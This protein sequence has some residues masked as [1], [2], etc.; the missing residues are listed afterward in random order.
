MTAFAEVKGRMGV[1]EPEPEAETSLSQ[2]LNQRQLKKKKKPQRSPSR[3]SQLART[4]RRPRRT[5]AWR[6]LR[7]CLRPRRRGWRPRQPRRRLRRLG[8]AAKKA[9]EVDVESPVSKHRRGRGAVASMPEEE[10]YAKVDDY[11][12][13]RFALFTQPSPVHLP[14]SP[15]AGPSAA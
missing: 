14:S 5:K 11:R 7:A 15:R 13:N 1:G 9:E 12:N 10:L 4:T 3:V 2:N 6:S 8:L